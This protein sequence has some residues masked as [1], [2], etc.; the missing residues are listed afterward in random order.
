MTYVVTVLLVCGCGY[1][2]TVRAPVNAR[3]PM[4]DH[5][6]VN[7]R[8]FRMCDFQH[9]FPSGRVM[10]RGTQD[11]EHRHTEKQLREV[12]RR[13]VHTC[14]ARAY[15]KR[16]DTRNTRPRWVCLRHGPVP[17]SEVQDVTDTPKQS[18]VIGWRRMSS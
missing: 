3:V 4:P 18:W 6:A 5:V 9:P 10:L 16:D 12:L 2:T 13:A 11:E 15:V 7:S 1:E 8:V 17:A 14:G